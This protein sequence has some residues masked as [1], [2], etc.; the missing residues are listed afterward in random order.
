VHEVAGILPVGT[1]GEIAQQ[2]RSMDTIEIVQS[3]RGADDAV[4][5]RQRIILAQS[6]N[7]GGL[8]EAADHPRRRSWPNVTA[9]LQT[10]SLVLNLSTMPV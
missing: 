10:C 4:L 8:E 1:T 3:Q 2:P 7:G 6:G 5:R 9:S